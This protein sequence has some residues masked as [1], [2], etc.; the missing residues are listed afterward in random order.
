[1]ARECGCLGGN[2]NCTYC[3]GS[4][5]VDHGKSVAA[6]YSQPL[7]PQQPH[8]Q[9]GLNF[10]HRYR[11]PTPEPLADRVPSRGI[12]CPYCANRFNSQTK[13]ETHIQSEHVA[14]ENDASEAARAKPLILVGGRVFE[15]RAV[16]RASRLRVVHPVSNARTVPGERRRKSDPHAARTTLRRSKAPLVQCPKCPSSVRLDRLPR[17]LRKTH[18]TIQPPSPPQAAVMPN[19]STVRQSTSG[20][21]A[22]QGPPGGEPRVRSLTAGRHRRASEPKFHEDE[23]SEEDVLYDIEV[24]QEERRLDGSRDLW[25]IREDGRF[26]SYPSYDDCDDESA[27]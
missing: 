14:A 1:M 22:A 9:N 13:M 7:K 15:R 11:A 2:E 8:P 21:N 26:G 20:K 18:G 10:G 4:G 16:E 24:S 25:Q 6:G 19:Q 3:Y 27:P 12:G 17:H 5:Y 23:P